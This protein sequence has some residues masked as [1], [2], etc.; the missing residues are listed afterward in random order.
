[1]TRSE[2]ERLARTPAD[3]IELRASVSF[4]V[5]RSMCHANGLISMQSRARGIASKV[6]FFPRRVDESVAKTEITHGSEEGEGRE[7]E[8]MR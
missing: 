4:D 3:E 6:H 7:R 5:R 2:N 8:R 1:M